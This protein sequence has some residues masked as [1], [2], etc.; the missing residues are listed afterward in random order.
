MAENN[1][2]S[3]V[4]MWLGLIFK[5]L[6]WI[7]TTIIAVSGLIL[8]IATYQHEE[9]SDIATITVTP[10]SLIVARASSN[11]SWNVVVTG[12]SFHGDSQAYVHY[13]TVADVNQPQPAGTAKETPFQCPRAALPVSVSSG[14]F[15]LGVT[16]A[17]TLPD[18]TYYIYAIGVN[19]GTEAFFTIQIGPAPQVSPLPAP[20]S[21][22]IP[23]GLPS[24]AAVP[25]C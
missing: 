22:N 21:G 7:A 9:T 4:A 14:D 20:T 23:T 19:S 5:P 11:G 16:I 2:E 12:S 3:K 1:D 8:S 25:R 18:G 10:S 15:T 13:P 24:M 6:A 17:K